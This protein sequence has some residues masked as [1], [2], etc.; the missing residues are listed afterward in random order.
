MSRVY[1]MLAGRLR[2]K[3]KHYMITCQ[4]GPIVSKSE[5][6]ANAHSEDSDGCKAK[7]KNKKKINKTSEAMRVRVGRNET[8]SYLQ[9]SD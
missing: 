4:P 6:S 3:N 5:T 2:I 1:T 8:D 7:W 9:D